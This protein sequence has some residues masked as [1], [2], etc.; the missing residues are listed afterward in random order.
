MEAQDA[1]GGWP[2]WTVMGI[3]DQSDTAYSA[4]AQ[5][6]A[7]SVLVRAFARSGD[8]GYLQ[9]AQRA[10]ALLLLPL[11]QG[12]TSRPA[13][14]GPILEEGPYPSHRAILNGWIFTLF[15]LYDLQLAGG[16]GPVS[17]KLEASLS[18]LTQLLPRYDAGFWSRYDLS[19][20]LASPFYHQLHQAQLQMLSVAFPQ[21]AA[22]FDPVC[23]RFA[24]QSAS[25]LG[26]TRAFLIKSWQKLREPP[27]VVVREARNTGTRTG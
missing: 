20:H 5:G 21:Y 24:A 6:E 14:E 2:V 3:G 10:A 13:P 25:R 7:V 1:E 27:A 4:M 12:G 23:A 15:G 22:Q 9:A 17:E 18:A 16:P 11:V 26:A 19:G 8:R